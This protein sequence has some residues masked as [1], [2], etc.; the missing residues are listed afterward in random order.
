MIIL[1]MTKAGDL[2]SKVFFRYYF[3]ILEIGCCLDEQRMLVASSHISVL[4]DC[5]DLLE[6]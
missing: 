1:K 6:I 3:S 4:V 2:S 5:S